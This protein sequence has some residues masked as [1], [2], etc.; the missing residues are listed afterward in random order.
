M[1]GFALSKFA[2]AGRKHII[3]I[4]SYW[5]KA[6]RHAQ[7]GLNPINQS[8]N[9]WGGVSNKQLPQGPRKEKKLIREQGQDRRVERD[10]V[11][12]VFGKW[13]K[14]VLK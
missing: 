10:A 11:L 8:I 14:K 13:T 3:N 9:F 1:K 5:L 4:F 7:A 6:V 12:N 2:A